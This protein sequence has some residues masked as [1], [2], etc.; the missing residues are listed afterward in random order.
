VPPALA[1]QVTAQIAA[2][3]GVAPD[4]VALEWGAPPPDL[5]FAPDT[6]ARLTGR[7]PNGW[8]AV[9]LRPADPAA[10]AWRVRAGVIGPVAVAARALPAGT[11]LAPGDLRT[12]SRVRW[13]APG[14]ETRAPAP[15]WEVRRPLA[16]GE[17]LT[18]PGVVPPALVLPGQSI[19][20]RWRRGGVEVRLAGT[21]LHAAREGETARATLVGRPGRVVG[22]VAGPATISLGGEG[23]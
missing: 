6:P 1:A 20:L 22:R 21:A 18:V 23:S 16:A 13:G 19:T 9:V 8:F 17:V 5:V 11:T 15:G 3:W 10:T 2:R 12:E 7:A 14:P 4:R